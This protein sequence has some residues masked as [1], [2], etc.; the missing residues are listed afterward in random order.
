VLTANTEGMMKHK[1][2]VYSSFLVVVVV[3][4]AAGGALGQA[5]ALV[6]PTPSLTP[7][8]T[9]T[10]TFSPLLKGL[11]SQLAYSQG[12]GGEGFRQAECIVE[13]QNWRGRLPAIVAE[14]R[15]DLTPE[16][17][18]FCLLGFGDRWPVQ[19]TLTSPSGLYY[20][21]NFRL[22]KKESDD[23]WSADQYDPVYLP[24]MGDGYLVKGRPA[25]GIQVSFPPDL[26]AGRWRIMASTDKLTASAMVDISWPKDKPDLY[27]P[28]GQPNPFDPRGFPASLKV[29]ESLTLAGAGLPANQDLPF[30]V[31]QYTPSG[32]RLVQASQVR[33]DRDGRFS[34]VFSAGGQYPA[35][36]YILYGVDDMTTSIAPFY[37]AAA[38]VTIDACPGAPESG[39]WL[40]DTVK[41]NPAFPSANNL[42]AQPGL[43]Q[44]RVGLLRLGQK[45]VLLEG[46]R[47]A[48][49]MT[50]WK[51]K[52]SAGQTG[53][54]GDGQGK[55]TWL[56]TVP[57]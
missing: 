49:Q 3:L 19:V 44:E 21:G 28:T 11:R 57:R 30:A 31:Y 48:D 33:T 2:P 20:Y 38:T 8:V 52:T 36:R 13:M 54:T 10:P 7:T 9:L 47:C 25:L 37:G 46:P 35:G 4:L 6:T 41:I 18:Y 53:W 56:V 40:G 50:W 14:N 45:A 23:Y 16:E 17:A 34:T 42:R 22:G 39:L 32:A 26:Q 43:K 5:A 55:E 15:S 12:G 27:P 51:V 24:G 29:G 1:M